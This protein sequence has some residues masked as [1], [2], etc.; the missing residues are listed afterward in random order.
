MADWKEI[1]E[2]VSSW[3]T[4]TPSADRRAIMA[5]IKASG[6]KPKSADAVNNYMAILVAPDGETVCVEHSRKRPSLWFGSPH[7]STLATAGIALEQKQPGRGR[8]SALDA[9]AAFGG[10]TAWA[11]RSPDIG[12]ASAALEALGLLG[13][14]DLD[15]E[16]VDRWIAV[17]RTA[18]P[19]LSRFDLPNP[20]FDASETDYKKERT[21]RLEEGL[22]TTASGNE[23]VESVRRAFQGYNLINWRVLDALATDWDKEEFGK[24]ILDIARGGDRL[25]VA[26]GRAVAAWMEAA[27]DSQRDYPRQIAGAIAMHLHPKDAVYFR[28]TVLDSLFR[29]A[30]GIPFPRSADPAVEFEREVAFAGKV[31]D[32]FAAR[33]LA[34][35]DLMDVQG[36]LWVVAKYERFDGADQE[37]TGEATVQKQ[38]ENSIP[39]NTILYGPPGTGKT[40][41][42]IREAVAICDGRSS[43]DALGGTELRKRHNELRQAGRIAFVT[44]H[45]SYSYEDFV[46]GLRPEV[47]SADSADTADEAGFRLVA[48][49]GILRRI[50]TLAAEA[51]ATTGRPF[52]TTGRRV[53]KMSLGRNV[54]ADADL[55]RECL[56]EGY[57]LLANEDRVDWSGLQNASFQTIA[58]KYRAITG[59]S[60]DPRSAV[61]G[62]PFY[63]AAYM[64]EGDIVV[65]SAGT[66][67]FHAVGVVSGPYVFDPSHQD[68]F[69]SRRSVDWL[70]TTEAP[71][72]AT[73]IYVH[74]FQRRTLHELSQ[75][76]VNWAALRELLSP[77]DENAPP[78]P[79]VLVIDEINRANV[80]KVFGE[81]ITLL[82]E[83]K[84]SGAENAV[85]LRLPYSGDAFSLPRNLY[86]VGTNTADR[87][88][89]LLDT[90]LRRRFAFVEMPPQPDLLGVIDGLDLRLLLTRLNER[91]EYLFDRD[92]LIGHAFFMAVRSRADM[93]TVMR[94]KVI[95]LLAE[96]FHEDW[97]R[98]L[99]V[100]GGPDQGFI[101]RIALPAPPGLV[102]EGE[103]RWG[104]AV[105][106]AFSEDAYAGLQM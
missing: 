12:R 60:V 92:H 20:D 39:L 22:A 59:K 38:S 2:S 19:G 9:A 76:K 50:A 44:F 85:T 96:Y 56:E 3:E 54:E 63:L 46:E 33:G 40:F 77:K 69:G 51:R 29:E 71:R 61:V 75:E 102:V 15:P 90:A 53:F 17:L 84:R 30:T 103:T 24:A 25:A 47:G 74:A 67:A 88:I 68:G 7:S 95:P 70:W 41:A 21:V 4:E 62:E 42:T 65:A 10:R 105:R 14:P 99:A 80:S 91:I 93:D 6:L 87:S 27:A 89:A 8:H 79:H 18:F 34:P 72:P 100:L 86:F 28:R 26:V 35:R 31:R 104:Y 43:A 82:E 23:A 49:A 37:M 64:R 106:S 52:E 13:L 1:D 94:R 36:A 97:E 55:R 16:V 32:A 5:L 73:D 11:L 101:E 78:P 58:E 66:T 57:V 81:L 45:Q 48:R 98:I 83:D